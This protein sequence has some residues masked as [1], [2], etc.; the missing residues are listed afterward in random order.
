MKR[1]R[2][3]AG[4]TLGLGAGALGVARGED[5][6]PS[7]QLLEF[8]KVGMDPV[9]FGQTLAGTR[10]PNLTY[11][12][13]FDDKESLETAWQAFLKHPER[14]ALKKDPTYQDTVSRIYNNN[15]RPI[16]G[17]QV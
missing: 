2:F 15:L 1:R 3:I 12:L 9:F 11:M 6:A 13:G 17:S 8:R 4:T 5:V 16:E 7:K 10:M 14:A